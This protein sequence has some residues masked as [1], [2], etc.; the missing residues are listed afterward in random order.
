MTF[1]WFLFKEMCTIQGWAH[2]R[3]DGGT[4][5]SL[6]QSLVNRFNSASSVER[7]FLLSSKAGGTGLNLIGANRLVLFDPDWNPATDAQAKPLVRID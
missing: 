3:L 7:V 1:L 4:E 5:V 6:R 2:F